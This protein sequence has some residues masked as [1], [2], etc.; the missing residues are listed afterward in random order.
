LQRWANLNI[1]K[2]YVER[3]RRVKETDEFRYGLEGGAGEAAPPI[4]SVNEG[5]EA[6]APAPAST[7]ALFALAVAIA[8]S[9]FVIVLTL[10]SARVSREVLAFEFGSLN[11]V[12]PVFPLPKVAQLND[13]VLLESGRQG[14]P[15]NVHPGAVVTARPEP[16]VAVEVV[17]PTADEIDVVGNADCDEHSG[18]SEVYH[19]RP[20]MDDYGRRRANIDIDIDL[21][22]RK[23]R[24]GTLNQHQTEQHCE[25]IQGYSRHF[26]S[27]EVTPFSP[28]NARDQNLC[29]R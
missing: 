29:P 16:V 24:R 5:N 6:L 27:H 19:R 10:S 14:L 23:G 3:C 9:V 28:V 15:R 26:S 8:L 7:V 4:F 20:L 21:G 13:L 11:L 12:D 17:V 1:L 22:K 25:S 18:L 2:A